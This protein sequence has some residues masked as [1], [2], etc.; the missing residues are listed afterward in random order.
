MRPRESRR[1]TPR[2]S[3]VLQS[4][5]YSCESAQPFTVGTSSAVESTGPPASSSSGLNTAPGCS[6]LRS[7]HCMWARRLLSPPH[8]E[9]CCGVG[10]RLCGPGGKDAGWRSVSLGDSAGQAGLMSLD[11]VRGSA[12]RCP[13]PSPLLTDG[14]R[15]SASSWLVL[16]DKPRRATGPLKRR[17]RGLAQA[18]SVLGD[19]GSPCLLW[20]LSNLGVVNL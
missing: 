11:S 19:K 10:G 2:P 13:T 9:T 6:S 17:P 7:S 15:N 20:D 8:P 4:I 18:S 1:G 14:C 16:S 5:Y 3:L 12:A